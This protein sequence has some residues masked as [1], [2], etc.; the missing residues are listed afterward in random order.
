MYIFKIFRVKN[1]RTPDPREAASN[2]GR[3]G[4]W[5][6][7]KGEGKGKGKGGEGKGWELPR[8]CMLPIRP[9]SHVRLMHYIEANKKQEAA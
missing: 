6:E 9:C 2:A 4:G 3:D 5:R 1:P 8:I 7:G